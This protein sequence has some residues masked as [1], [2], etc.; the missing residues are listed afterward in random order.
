MTSSFT[1]VYDSGSRLIESS[2]TL[3]RQLS[4]SNVRLRP[5]CSCFM[6]PRNRDV[7]QLGLGLYV[8]GICTGMLFLEK[9][10]FDIFSFLLA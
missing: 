5:S 4:T 9:R 7:S 3:F 10:I 8:N 2:K 6:T 1:E